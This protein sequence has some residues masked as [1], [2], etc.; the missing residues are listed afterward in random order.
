METIWPALH[1][2]TAAHVSCHQPTFP[3]HGR[4][5]GENT[6]EWGSSLRHVATL[7]TVTMAA[8]RLSRTVPFSRFNAGL[9]YRESG[10]AWYS[11]RALSVESRTMTRTRPYDTLLKHCAP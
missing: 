2:A 11:L 9:R 4:A 7:L 8:F 1:D 6:Q 3:L 10:S 5:G